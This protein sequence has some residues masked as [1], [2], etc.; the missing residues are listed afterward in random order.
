MKFSKELCVEEILQEAHAYGLRYEVDLYAKKILD[1][2][3]GID[4]VQ[5]YQLAYQ[6]WIK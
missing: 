6:E 2:S 5:A 4:K 3:P 1:E